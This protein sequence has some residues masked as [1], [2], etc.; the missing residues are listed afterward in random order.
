MVQEY[1]RLSFEWG[2]QMHAPAALSY[3]LLT[4]FFT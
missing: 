3:R 4:F 2:H 1:P